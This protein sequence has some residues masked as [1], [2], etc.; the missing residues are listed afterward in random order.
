MPLFY[1]NTLTNTDQ[2]LHLISN[3]S[4][5]HTPLP[6]SLVRL[7]VRPQVCEPYNPCKDNTH[8]CHPHA[9]CRY[10]GLA[11]EVLYRCRCVVGYAGDGFLCAEDSDLDGWPNHG[12][13]CERNAT[14]HCQRV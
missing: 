10:L 14:Y 13:T 4:L 6:P 2:R 1:S 8:T 12:L 3:Q 11:S 9:L 7:P 5:T